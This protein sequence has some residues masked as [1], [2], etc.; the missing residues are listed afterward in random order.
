MNKA[1][2]RQTR[3]IDRRP[4]RATVANRTTQ[5]SQKSSPKAEIPEILQSRRSIAPPAR[6][7]PLSSQFSVTQEKISKLLGKI[8]VIIRVVFACFVVDW[9][10]SARSGLLWNLSRFD[11]CRIRFFGHVD[12]SRFC[13]L[14]RTYFP[15]F[16][17]TN[18]EDKIPRHS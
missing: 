15:N 14:L 8:T 11:R 7:E 5:K 1:A 6:A 9:M 4:W 12:V 13:Q 3:K 2:R 18:Q 16:E 10:E 17:E